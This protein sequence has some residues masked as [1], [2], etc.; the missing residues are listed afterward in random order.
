MNSRI[1]NFRY[2]EDGHKSS[3][4]ITIEGDV[5]PPEAVMAVSVIGKLLD[6]LVD[7]HTNRL[8]SMNVD[9]VDWGKPPVMTDWGTKKIEVIKVW[10]RCTGAGLKEAKEAVE[11][12]PTPLPRD[13]AYGYCKADFVADLEE[14]GATVV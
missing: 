14:A 10:R 6:E 7:F 5:L 13:L 3:L 12:C 11:S 8:L 1:T 9:E 2:H 4:D